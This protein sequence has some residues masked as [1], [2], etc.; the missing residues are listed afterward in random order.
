MTGIGIVAGKASVLQYCYSASV[1]TGNGPLAERL[2]IIYGALSEA[3]KIHQ[4][5]AVAIEQVFVARNPRSALVLGHARGSALLAAVNHGLPVTEYSALQIKRSVVGTGSATKK[6]VQHMVQVLLSLQ[7]K[8][9]LDAADGLACAICHLH[10]SA[11]L[12]RITAAS[13]LVGT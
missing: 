4:P 1:R 6:Q 5:D 12:G 10:T 9:A 11:S 3:I 8:P 13:R 7:R 2:A